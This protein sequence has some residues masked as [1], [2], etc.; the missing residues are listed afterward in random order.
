[1]EIPDTMIN[2]AFKKPTGYKYYKAKK[3]KSDQEENVPS[4][5]KK[6]V[7]PKKPRSLTMADNIVEEQAAVE[8]AK[9][10]SI[11]EQHR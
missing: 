3:A 6:N 8:L 10:L 4:T 11:D 2:D 7:V 5:F 9:S 1:M